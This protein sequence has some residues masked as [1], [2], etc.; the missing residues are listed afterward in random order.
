MKN[1][2]IILS[3]I[4]MIFTSCGEEN[5]D[6]IFETIVVDSVMVDSV[7]MGAGYANDIFYS[8]KNGEVDA[9]DRMN[10]DI[11][12]AVDAMSSAILI[13][14]GAGVQLKVQ[15]IAQDWEWAD[16]TDTTG[17]FARE[18]L[19]NP[20]TT[21]GEGAFGANGTTHPNYGWGMYNDVSHNIEGISLYIIKTVQGNYKKIFIEN[22]FSADQKYI[23][24]YADINGENEQVVTLELAGVDKNFMYYSLETNEELDREPLNADWDI[25]FTKW[26]DNMMNYN[27]TGVLQNDGVNV[28][29]LDEVSD[30]VNIEFP[31]EGF[32]E[33][34]SIIGYD[35]KSFNMN[36]FAYDI[37]ADQ[38]F[39]I[40]DKNEEVH[41]LV[42]KSFDYTI[43]KAVFEITSKVEIEVEVE[44]DTF[45]N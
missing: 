37:I 19:L 14:E 20:D 11:A 21:W 6:P 35:W 18:L 41:K 24:K 43:G 31:A 12:F 44:G 34:T 26:T 7:T 29:Q 39:F 4:L 17:L 42:F 30:M 3:V 5:P 2:A 1:I 27:V 8:F 25:L 40:L 22:K 36:T 15:P 23:F 13:N 38:V 10:W 28:I 9:V 45:D 16:A 33:N 32:Q